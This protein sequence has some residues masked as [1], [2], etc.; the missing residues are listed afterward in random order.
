[1]YLIKTKGAGEISDYIQVRDDNFCLITYILPHKI[2]LILKR[3]DLEKHLETVKNFIKNSNYGE[4]T[5]I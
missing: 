3:L 4:I 2:G 1:M 5:K